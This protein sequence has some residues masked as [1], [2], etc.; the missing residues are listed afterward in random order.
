MKRYKSIFD[1][2]YKT[3]YKDDGNGKK[4]PVRYEDDE[5]KDGEKDESCDKKDKKK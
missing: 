2:K 1:E 5:E 4:K 3:K